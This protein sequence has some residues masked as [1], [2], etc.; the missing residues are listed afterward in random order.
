MLRIVKLRQPSIEKKKAT[1]IKKTVVTKTPLTP[2]IE[3]WIVRFHLPNKHNRVPTEFG[4]EEEIGTIQI[5]QL[6]WN[7]LPLPKNTKHHV[8]N[9]LKKW[10]SLILNKK[11]QISDG[12]FH[13]TDTTHTF[14]NI[15][16][17]PQD[18]LTIPFQ[19]VYNTYFIPLF[20][21]SKADLNILS[22]MNTLPNPLKIEISHHFERLSST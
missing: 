16:I 1:E 20:T 17:Q 7:K 11:Y 21:N 6:R 8:P 15:I 12:V 4:L 13:F 19:F 10:F 9:K 22:D 14:Y 2:V 5:T 3:S 18:T